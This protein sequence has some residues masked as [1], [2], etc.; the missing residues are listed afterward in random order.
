MSI[1][2]R[3]RNSGQQGGGGGGASSNSA[4]LAGTGGN[5]VT[6][7]ADASLSNEKVLT[8]GSSASIRTDGASVYVDANTA[9]FA[10]SLSVG[11]GG[12][13]QSSLGSYGIL[14]GSGTA[15]IKSLSAMSAGALVVGS[16]PNLHP[17]ILQTAGQAQMLITSAGAVGGLAWVNT[18]GAGAAAAAGPVYPAM[19]TLSSFRTF[20]IQ[21]GNVG[22]GNIDLYTVP[23][24]RRATYQGHTSMMQ[25]NTAS[26]YVYL[27]TNN[28]FYRFVGNSLANPNS[29][30]NGTSYIFE[31][32]ETFGVSVIS[33]LS[34]G[35]NF[36]ARMFEFG[37]D[38]NIKSVKLLT[39]NS[40]N[41]TVYTCPTTSMAYLLDRT[42]GTFQGAN[43]IT[44]YFSNGG[45]GSVLYTWYIVKSGNPVGIDFIFSTTNNNVNTNAVATEVSASCLSGGD[46][47]S[48]FTNTNQLRQFAWVNLVE[49]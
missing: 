31:A 25:T 7:S 45:S 32:G 14:T 49:Q 17:M 46:Y 35:V 2:T 27:K 40:G 6:F 37:T 26:V 20:M 34:T 16:G 22:N 39:F 4:G 36:N 1:E 19:P 8:S 12:T 11:S 33:G 48:I 9:W 21:T 15:A 38:V 41:N 30:I 23:A 42:S 24:G 44:L 10:G 28:A 18:S 47:I 43:N 3:L 29:S 13:G 5:F